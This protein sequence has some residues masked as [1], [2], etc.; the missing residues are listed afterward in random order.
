MENNNVEV[1]E[2]LG[3]A[4]I[5]TGVNGK[6]IALGVLATA[7][8]CGVGYEIYKVTKQII[9]HRKNKVAEAEV[10]EEDST[11]ESK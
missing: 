5:D 4:V 9:A 10:K 11:T 6:T 8:V 1:I 7:V 3:E 2:E